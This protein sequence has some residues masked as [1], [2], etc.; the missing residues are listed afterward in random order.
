MT[1]MI[2]QAVAAFVQEARDL[3]SGLEDDFLSLETGGSKA[4]IDEI[5]RAL[6]TIKGSGAMFGYTRL[7]AFTH[8]FESAFERVRAGTLAVDRALIDVC[9]NAC[10]V[11]AAFLD[12]GGDTPE[13]EALLGSEH[14]V[15]VASRLAALTGDDPRPASS[16]RP[17]PVAP[18]AA[19]QMRT[20]RIRFAP[21]A[22]ALRNGMRPD[23]LLD[24]LRGLGR[25]IVAYDAE[26]VPP[27]SEL[28]PADATLAYALTLQTDAPRSAIEEVFI[29]ADDAEL[30][31]VEQ[32]DEPVPAAA[33][34]P[35]VDAAPVADVAPQKPAVPRK[36]AARRDAGSESI[37]VASGRLD[38][39]MDSLGELVIAQARLDA[40]VQ[41]ID[42]PA[43]EGVAEE[44]ARLITGLR[45]ATL[46]LRM[47]PIETVFGKFKRVVR[48]LA[49]DLKKD[50]RLVVEGGETE[51]D[52]TV[53]DR[54]GDPL[55][56]MIRNAIDHGIEPAEDRVEAGKPP[57]GTLRLT[58]RQEGGEI[59]ISIQDDGRGLDLDAIR[60]RAVERGVI[61][62]DAALS[63]AEL[64]QL[65]FEPGFSTAAEVT[66][67]SG[68]GVGMDA[69]KSTL[70]ALGGAVD[71]VSRVGAGARVT[72]R[73]PVTMAIIDG[74][75]VRLGEGV[76]VVPL[77][78]V[79]ECVELQETEAAVRSGRSLL[80]IR[81]EMVPFLELARLFNQ[82]G[83][84]GARRRVVIVRVDGARVGLVVDDILG[85]GQTVIKS[86]SCFHSGVPGLGGATILGDGRVALIVDVATLVRSAEAS[87]AGGARWAA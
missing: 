76:Y 46:S 42:D 67:V 50:V 54:I 82:P 10:D 60:A 64:R 35:T 23:L 28:D 32:A 69:V 43:L 72:L 47:L 55:V 53:I 26:A 17:D 6:H 3:L 84:P 29:F 78:S 75:R 70:D 30:Q 86:L 1:A 66:S 9:L 79:E 8:H 14:A 61:G 68:R 24:E 16:S 71:V 34:E 22:G 12:L 19:A 58:A 40:V 5:F 20:W 56:H 57:T 80:S 37:R 44:V 73:L 13:A 21:E 41:G 11:M 65:I 49:G 27:L 4:K 77:S 36:E 81:D 87:R 2:D 52:K 85:Q 59:L 45:D 62:P 39:M 38:E 18:D 25:L 33:P 51:V 48:D 63:D 15:A 7:S 74:L 31:I 83:D